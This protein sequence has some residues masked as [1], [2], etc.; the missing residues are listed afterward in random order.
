MCRGWLFLRALS[1]TTHWP[2]LSLGGVINVTQATLAR[3][4]APEVARRKSHLPADGASKERY[5]SLAGALAS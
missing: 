4:Q 5:R 2:G 1:M 3:A